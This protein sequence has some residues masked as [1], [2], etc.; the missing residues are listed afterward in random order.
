[1]TFQF[2]HATP[3]FIY[4]KGNLTAPAIHSTNIGTRNT[5][6]KTLIEAAL[7][8]SKWYYSGTIMDSDGLKESYHPNCP[9]HNVNDL[10][11]KRNTLE[12]AWDLCHLFAH[13]E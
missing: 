4:G 5:H 2:Q 13:R 7:W 6:H 9:E 1:M 3:V 12:F 11:G 10:S 8:Y